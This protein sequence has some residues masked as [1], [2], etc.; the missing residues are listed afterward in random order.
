MTELLTSLGD[1]L[2]AFGDFL[3]ALFAVIGPV[4][5]VFAWTAFWYLAVDW[6]KLRATLGSGGWVVPA[7]IAAFAVIVRV[8]TSGSDITTMPFGPGTLS[9]IVATVAWT[10]LLTVLA[11]SAGAAQVSRGARR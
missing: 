7:L 1:L 6:T 3:L 2:A 9:P 8:V 5:P 11:I 4:L 10:S